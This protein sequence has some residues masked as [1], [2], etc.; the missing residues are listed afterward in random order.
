ME[1][2]GGKSG[3]SWIIIVFRKT[4]THGDGSVKKTPQTLRF[5]SL[6]PFRA[7]HFASIT[8]IKIE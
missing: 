6:R 4:I 1:W 3:L 2:G 5:F 7:N 8:V